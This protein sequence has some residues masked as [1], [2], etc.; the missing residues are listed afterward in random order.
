MER[1]ENDLKVSILKCKSTQQ[2]REKIREELQK[3]IHLFPKSRSAQILLKPNLNSNMNALTGNTTDLRILVSVIEF[4]KEQGYRNIIIGEGTSSGFY[5]NRINVFSRLRIDKLT[6][7][8]NLKMVDLNYAQPIKINFENGVEAEVAK[9]CKNADFFINLPKLKMHFETMMSVTLKSLIGCLVGLENKQRVH[10]SLFKNIIHLNEIIQPDLYIVDGLIAMEGTGPSNGTPIKMDLILIGKDPFLIDLVCAKLVGVD[11]EIISPLKI[12][13]QLGYI[14]PDHIRYVNQIDL[15]PYLK[16]FK[17]PKV[18]LLVKFVNDQ[19]WQKY[20]I[21]I[22]LSPGV[23][24]LFN[25]R[26]IGRLLNFLGLRQDVF[27]MEDTEISNIYVVDNEKCNDCSKICSDYCP[28][29]LNLPLQVGD[30]ERGCIHCLYCYLVCPQKAIKFEGKLG[31]LSEQ[32]R[33]Y[34]KFVRGGIKNE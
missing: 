2:I 29:S 5:R 18:N 34:D 22:R 30:V 20:F 12:A 1:I 8:Y 26:L 7:Q 24:F 23:N 25:R 27:I 16:H 17:K 13:K 32:I 10:Y 31:F 28:M 9:I 6:E 4:L 11:Y 14:T 19:R 33:Q 15:F 3:H 21:K